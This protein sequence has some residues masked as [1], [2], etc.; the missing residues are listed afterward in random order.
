MRYNDTLFVPFASISQQY[1]KLYDFEFNLEFI[2][3][4]EF[5]RKYQNCISPHQVFKATPARG[6]YLCRLRPRKLRDLF[7]YCEFCFVLQVLFLCR[8]FC[9]C[10][11]GFVFVLRI[12][13][14][15]LCVLLLC[16]SDLFLYC[17]F[18]FCVLRFAFVLP[19]FLLCYEFRFYVV[20]F[21][22]CVVHFVFV[23]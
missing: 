18:C 19:R 7:P 21:C 14:F 6:K 23:L 13:F 2:C 20:R 11:V 1:R 9:F 10:V 8:V 5:F 17:E 16:C 22:F 12:L 4:S 3:T 15:L